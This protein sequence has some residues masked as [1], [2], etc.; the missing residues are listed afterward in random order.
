MI[1]LKILTVVSIIRSIVKMQSL[2][3]IIMVKEKCADYND[4]ND[5]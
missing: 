2:K 3:A 5:V 1:S 4:N